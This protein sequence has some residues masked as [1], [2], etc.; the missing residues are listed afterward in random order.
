MPDEKQKDKINKDLEE[1]LKNGAGP[2]I[3]RFALACLG[4]VPFAG[5][6]IG[7]LGGAWSEKEQSH[8]NKIFTT[9]LKLQEE[10]I[11]EI[12]RT[13]IEVM[14]RLDQTDEKVQERIES[15]EYLK[16]IKKS[17]RDW[18]AAESEEKRVLIRNL[19]ANSASTRICSDDVIRMFIDWIS[20][21]SEAHFAVIREIYQKP[22]STRQEVWQKI[23]GEQARE[24]SAEADLF[25]LLIY[26]LS[27]GHVIRQHREKDYHGNFIVR[28]PQ[29]QNRSTP[30]GSR[31]ATSAF[32]DDKQYEL[33]ELGKQFVHYTMNEIVS[34]I[35]NSS[36]H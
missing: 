10:E 9:W 13:I 26:D 12:G 34:K 20:N 18:S 11:K 6:A 4:A 1:A 25:K 7:G 2:K 27:S 32:D 5:G 29:K 17:F 33:T 22:G 21:Y 35:G 14:I 3:A 31:T 8:F 15:P 28:G 16:L 36:A 23:H 30:V 19:L 24:D